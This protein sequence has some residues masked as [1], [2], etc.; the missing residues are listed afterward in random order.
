MIDP[1][2][3][4]VLIILGSTGNVQPCRYVLM[5][6]DQPGVT[7]GRRSLKDRQPGG[8]TSTDGGVFID[9]PGD[10]L[11]WLGSEAVMIFPVALGVSTGN[12]R[13]ALAA[14]ITFG[15]TGGYCNDE[16]HEERSEETYRRR[17]ACVV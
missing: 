6:Q 4:E 17:H 12:G 3:N 5:S 15:S 16:G 2:T 10:V 7:T 1:S 14:Q 8:T 9:G 13:R 11:G